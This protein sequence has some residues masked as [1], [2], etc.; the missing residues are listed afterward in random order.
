MDKMRGFVE[1]RITLLYLPT[2][3]YIFLSLSLSLVFFLSFESV[4]RS[5]TSINPR[6][7]N[8]FSTDDDDDDYDYH[9]YD[10][11]V[12]DLSSR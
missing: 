2:Y 12:L 7:P 9:S 10:I 8:A 3:I 6:L 11:E 4:C 1:K 5:Q